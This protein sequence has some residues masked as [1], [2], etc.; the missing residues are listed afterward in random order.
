MLYSIRL[1]AWYLS[2]STVY[3]T[4]PRVDP[5]SPVHPQLNLNYNTVNFIHVIFLI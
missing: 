4:Q 2:R 1:K 5:Y 3:G